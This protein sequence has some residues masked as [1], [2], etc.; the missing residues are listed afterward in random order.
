MAWCISKEFRFE[1]AHKL[2]YHD[3]KCARLHGHSGR[4]VVFVGSN[5]LLESGPKTGMVQ[6]FGDIKKVV[7]PLIDQ[8]LDHH[9]L[10]DTLQTEETTAEVIS[11]W[12]FNKLKPELDNLLAVQVD[13]T[14]T[15]SCFYSESQA[16]LSSV[17]KV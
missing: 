12:V 13:E 1:Y 9:Y 17:L 15:S 4:L 10:N 6:D 3:G 11:R 14:C 5:T 8:Y 16:L 2:P 7:K